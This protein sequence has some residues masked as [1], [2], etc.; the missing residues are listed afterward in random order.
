M[1]KVWK[2]FHLPQ[3]Q[4]M[5][6]VHLARNEQW[7]P[8]VEKKDC[9]AWMGRPLEL[10]LLGALWY[11][12]RG[13][14]FDDIEEATFISTNPIRHNYRNTDR[15]NSR[16]ARRGRK[17]QKHPKPNQG[18]HFT[19]WL[20]EINANKHSTTIKAYHTE[21]Y[22]LKTFGFMSDPRLPIKKN[23][24]NSLQ[25]KLSLPSAIQSHLP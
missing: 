21:K 23:F 8:S 19:R 11:L 2:H 15:R 22:C 25:I 6:L 5:E 16:N 3:E 14:T 24:E 12:G 18:E 7:S 20:K 10:M 9:T 13:F 17:T 4:F 1:N